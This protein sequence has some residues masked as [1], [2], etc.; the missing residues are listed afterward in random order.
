MNKYEYD[1]DAFDAEE[2]EMFKDLQFLQVNR[3]L[4]PNMRRRVK[5]R[6][7]PFDLSPK[8]FYERFR[9]SKESVEA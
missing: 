2:A 9:F 5:Q 6:F 8:E 7:D 3:P 1:D 4:R